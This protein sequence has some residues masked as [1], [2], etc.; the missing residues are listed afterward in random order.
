VRASRR[1]Q[2]EDGL[3]P[4][5]RRWP[6]QAE[7]EA[8][9]V[10]DPATAPRFQDEIQEQESEYRSLSPM[11]VAGLVVSLASVFAFWSLPFVV[12]AAAGALLSV[13]A[14]RRIDGDP[15]ALAGRGVALL[16]LAIAVGSGSAGVARFFS[17]QWRFEREA[18]AIADLW[19][20]SVVAG[21]ALTAHQ[22]TY[23]PDKRQPLDGALP[24]AYQNNADLQTAIRDYVGQQPMRTMLALGRKAH[25]RY[26]QTEAPTQNTSAQ[27]AKEVYAVTYDDG[28]GKRSF[29]IHITVGRVSR[30]QTKDKAWAISYVIGGPKPIGWVDE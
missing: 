1:Q 18:R 29:F 24:R 3:P 19:V 21:D 6:I 15:M 16:G 25:V 20:E 4:A 12:V 2:G 28:D 14:V 8:F 17:Y 7:S 30:H 10:D 26:Y 5:V 13:V 9:L 27:V 11:A 23:A 22:L